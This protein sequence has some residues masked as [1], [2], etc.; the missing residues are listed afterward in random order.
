TVPQQ[1]LIH[2]RR[3]GGDEVHVV[4][5]LEPFLHDIHVQETEEAAAEAEAQRLRYL[6]LVMQ[7]RVVQ[8]QFLQRVAQRFVLV[9]LDRIQ[10]REDLRLDF[11]EAGERILR[12][13]R[14]ERH[15]VADR[16]R[17]EF[18]VGR[19]KQSGTT[20]LRGRS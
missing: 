12:R 4:F 11:L 17:L 15:R 9:G 18:L 5:A 20:R 1:Y 14:R 19:G 6:G 8:L 2:D 13:S 3:R 16:S 7:R 10:A